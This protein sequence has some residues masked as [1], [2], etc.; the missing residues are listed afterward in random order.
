MKTYVNWMMKQSLIHADFW[1][2]LF[3]SIANPVTH[4]LVMENV[5]SQLIA[6]RGLWDAVGIIVITA[7]FNKFGDRIYKHFVA[8]A[9]CENI[10]YAI[11]ITGVITK[12]V[13]ITTMFMVESIAWILLTKNL[14]CCCSR[15]RRFLY[16]SEEREKFDNNRHVATSAA[17]IIGY[18][19]AM[20]VVPEWLA[21]SL[22]S[23]GIICGNMF[24][25]LA[26][27]QARRIEG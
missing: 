23:L 1:S 25:I 18:S 6:A 2:I 17:E 13:S 16:E 24:S 14:I 15:I 22:I 7:L 9:M 10:V 26:Y 12:V 27:K 19:V 21:W 3:I 5:S 4:K 8:I 11:I 20:L